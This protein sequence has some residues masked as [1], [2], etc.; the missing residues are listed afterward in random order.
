MSI[1]KNK[2]DNCIIKITVRLSWGQWVNSFMSL[3]PSDA[4][5][6]CWKFPQVRRSEADNFGGFW[7]SFFNFMFMI[8][9][10]RHEDLQLFWLSFR[11]C[12]YALTSKLTIQHWFRQ[13]LGALTAP[14]H[15]RNQCWIFFFALQQNGIWTHEFTHGFVKNC[16]NIYLHIDLQLW[17]LS[18]ANKL[19]ETMTKGQKHKD[20]KM[21]YK[22]PSNF[23]K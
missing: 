21:L 15:Y 18:M 23:V 2:I 7:W 3:R 19:I 20:M 22:R 11:H 10:S 8:W 6:Q 1:G 4:Y 12:I 5:M 16:F 17:Q 9:D 14:S 13:W